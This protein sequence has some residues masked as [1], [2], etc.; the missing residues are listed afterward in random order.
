MK[1]MLI[2]FT[3][4]GKVI[5]ALIDNQKL[6]DLDIED[7]KSETK[8]ANIYKGK[9]TRIEPSLEAAFIEYGS[10]KQG[11]LPL[12]EIAEEY[13]QGN[14]LKNSRLHIKDILQEGQEIIVQIDKEQRGNKGAALTTFISLA[15]SY[16]VLM[17]NNPNI[18]AIS[19]SIERNS[20]NALTKKI[21]F[22]KLPRNMGLIIRT[23]GAGQ[24][25]DALKGDLDSLLKHWDAIN[26]AAKSRSAP[27]LIHQ[28]SNIFKRF[29]Q[30]HLCPDI[31]EIVID[32]PEIH[33]LACNYMTDIGQSY[34]VRNIQLYTDS[35]PI[36]SQY[37]IDTQIDSL[38]K[39]KIILP[40][41]GC[42]VID[43]T[44]A[45]IAI[46]INSARSTSGNDIAETAFNTNIEAVEEISRQ[47]RLRD[48]SGLIVIDFIDMISLSH[49]RRVVNKLREETS[50]DRARIQI[51]NISSF[52][53]LQ[54]SR[55]RLNPSLRESNN[56]DNNICSCCHGTGIIKNKLYY[57]SILP[58]IEQA[59]KRTN[60]E[61]EEIYAIPI[62]IVSYFLRETNHYFNNFKLQY[63]IC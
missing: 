36:F 40:S 20:R 11:F 29:F 22:L 55:Q 15:G 62:N 5:I 19:R 21:S 35:I 26:I 42:I 10:D 54:M 41:G 28:E 18:G 39:R 56:H 58:C 13:F 30:E 47:L 9:I 32:D 52:G 50:K 53:L 59:L 45:L 1:R 2:N 14:N 24:S 46:D 37:Q 34:F 43:T 61:E 57:Q 4:Q 7:L 8:T 3:P 38:F 49:Q 48:L 51:S 6:S 16:L 25:I 60:E 12:K 44:E 63:G 33:K 31:D 17:P 23:A 27:F